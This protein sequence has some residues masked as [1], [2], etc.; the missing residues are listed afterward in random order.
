MRCPLQNCT[1][2]WGALV[3]TWTLDFIIKAVVRC[4][5][6]NSAFWTLFYWQTTC[7]VCI[8]CTTAAGK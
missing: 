4:L 3:T 1:T 7:T 6:T 2:K 8:W 5:L